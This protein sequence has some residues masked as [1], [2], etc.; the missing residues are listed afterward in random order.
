V[1]DSVKILLDI[2]RVLS[3]GEL[4]NLTSAAQAAPD[5]F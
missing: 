4:A 1:N 5:T 3:V 2:S